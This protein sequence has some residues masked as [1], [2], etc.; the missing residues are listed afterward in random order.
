MKGTIQQDGNVKGED[1]KVYLS[2]R[3]GG[4][5]EEGCSKIVIGTKVVVNN[6]EHNGPF[7]KMSVKNL[8]GRQVE[9]DV[10]SAGQGSN[11]RIITISV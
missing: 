5:D 10:S 6:N 9:F 7:I 11:Y 3:R 4:T 1:G 2:I 8:I